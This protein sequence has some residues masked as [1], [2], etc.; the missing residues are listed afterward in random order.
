M[1]V[2]N[3]DDPLSGLRRLQSL[4]VETGRPALQRD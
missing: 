3:R 4:V 1:A 2:E